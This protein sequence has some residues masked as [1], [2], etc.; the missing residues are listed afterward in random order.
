MR[1]TRRRLVKTMSNNGSATTKSAV[2]GWINFTSPTWPDAA[3]NNRHT[4]IN[5]RSLLPASPKNVFGTRGE[6]L[7]LETKKASREALIAKVTNP[8]AVSVNK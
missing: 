1:I 8:G 6:S 4:T 3:A 7:R 2:T 5:P